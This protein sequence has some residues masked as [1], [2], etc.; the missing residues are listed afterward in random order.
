MATFLAFAAAAASACGGA[1]ATT[2]LRPSSTVAGAGSGA[3]ATNYLSE[4]LNVM[5]SNSINRNRINWTDFRSQVFARGQTARS[6]PET[7]PAVSLALSL[8]DDHHSFFTTPSG[9]GVG[10]P[11]GIRCIAPAVANPTVPAD[12]GYVRIASFAGAD[13]AA[14]RAFADAVQ[15][16]IRVADRSDLI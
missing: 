14:V 5:E 4:I 6:I 9:T 12:V 13:A 3:V 7:Y 11:S 15:D 2:P 10:N 1:Q 16:Q 8:L